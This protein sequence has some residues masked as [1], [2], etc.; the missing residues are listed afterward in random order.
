[1]GWL[2]EKKVRKIGNEY[3]IN[4]DLFCLTDALYLFEQFK[5]FAANNDSSTSWGNLIKF[6]RPILHPQAVS[7]KEREHR[8]QYNSW[9][10]KLSAFGLP[11]E[12][13]IPLDKVDFNSLEELRKGVVASAIKAYNK[14]EN[15]EKYQP[16]A[17]A[18]VTLYTMSMKI[19]DTL[20]EKKGRRL[21]PP[22]GVEKWAMEI[23]VSPTTLFNLKRQIWG[24]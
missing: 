2:E 4:P 23:M 12:H 1:M 24:Q 17:L 20:S 7:I 10:N 16:R 18:A 8:L 9:V 6:I 15:V 14:V 13:E 19:Y 11:V 3:K 22:P 5:M 21:S